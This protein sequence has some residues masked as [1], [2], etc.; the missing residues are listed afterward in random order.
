MQFSPASP[1]IVNSKLQPFQG[2]SLKNENYGVVAGIRNDTSRLDS[3]F[4]LPL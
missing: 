2:Q 3:I 1:K 4:V